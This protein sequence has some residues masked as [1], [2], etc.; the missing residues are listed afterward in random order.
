M[1]DAE[2]PN[3]YYA[4]SANPFSSQPKIEG[5]VAADV[6]IVGGGYTGLSAALHLAERGYKVALVEAR[7]IGWGASGRN[8]GQINTGLRKGPM[9][10]V[11]LLGRARARLLFDLSEEARRLIRERVARHDIR[12]DLKSGSLVV[13]HRPSEAAWMRPEIDAYAREFGYDKLE[14]VSKDALGHH[15]G[16]VIYHGGIHDLGASHLH[17]LNY[18][19]GLAKAAMA[20]GA[21]LYEQSPAQSIETT[22]SAVR[23]RTAK[24]AVRAK[25]A[26]I[27][28]NGYLGDLYPRIATRIM[29]IANFVIATEP[30]G[31]D[32]AR[33]LIPSDV[34]VCDT[35]FVVNYFRLSADR[36]MLWGGGEK[37]T[38]WPPRDIGAFV[39]PHMLQ[40]FPGLAPRRIEFGWSGVL[41]ITMNR[42]PQLGRDGAV[43]FAHGYSGQGVA[44]AC[45]AGK[46]VAEAIAGTAER[47]DVFASVSHRPFPGGT[48]LR[49]PLVVLAM[50]YY[51]L[52]DRF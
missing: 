11:G 16:S 38:P 10:L 9:A 34:C 7:R 19:L 4:A 25:Y 33:R 51:A 40:A 52:R 2:H 22:G 44:T 32:E 24:G 47:F 1:D 8:G 20:A 27:A 36:R 13:A 43:F 49:H 30:L 41:A 50:L 18:A 31:D 23:V 12:C 46:L 45:M 21:A 29:P 14:F 17:P 48:L 37:Y 42:L 15:L 5:D 6:A 35:R 26:L 39:R 3:S 28:C